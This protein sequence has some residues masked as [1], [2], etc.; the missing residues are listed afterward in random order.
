MSRVQLC[1]PNL[2]PAPERPLIR[3]P[4][5]KIHPSPWSPP[6]VSVYFIDVAAAVDWAPSL[7]ATG[8]NHDKVISGGRGAGEHGVK[9]GYQCGVGG[10]RGSKA[11]GD[12]SLFYDQRSGHN[13]AFAV[14]VTARV[15][16]TF[17]YYRPAPVEWLCGPEWMLSRDSPDSL[18]ICKWFMAPHA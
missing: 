18:V 16:A 15:R 8:G 7:P 12:P 14:T 11:S 2:L 4:L 1:R 5:Q 3:N 13:C 10:G 9:G 17:A 6:P